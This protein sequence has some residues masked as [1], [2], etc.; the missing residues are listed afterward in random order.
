MMRAALLLGVVAA[1]GGGLGCSKQ[2]TAPAPAPL[3]PSPSSPSPDPG[4]G[5]APSASSLAVSQ[6]TISLFQR[7][8]ASYVQYFP[9][10]LVLT[11][12]S[13][14]GGATVKGIEVSTGVGTNEY[15]CTGG[16]GGDIRIN[17]G[18]TRDLAPGLSYCMPYAVTPAESSQVA[19]QI[20]Y[21]DDQGRSGRLETTA[22]VRGCTLGGRPGQV[23]CR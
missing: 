21:V 11:E 4:P 5:P 22:D 13:G 7:N 20:T 3:A 23:I 12:T 1:L 15:D 16:I 19:L 10:V 14:Q 2:P 17:S 8:G 6:L 9:V 18:E